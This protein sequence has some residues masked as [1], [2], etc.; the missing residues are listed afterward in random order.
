MEASPADPVALD[1][2]SLPGAGAPVSPTPATPT[3]AQVLLGVLVVWQILFL[4]AANALDV[5]RHAQRVTGGNEEV[6][7]IVDHV[8][9][10]LGHRKGHWYEVSY[11]LSRW[12]LIFNQN[13]GWGLFSPGVGDWYS[14]PQ[15][16]MRWDDRAP[17]KPALPGG[18]EPVMLRG[19]QEP[20]DLKSFTRWGPWRFQ[21]YEDYF[22]ALDLR[23]YEGESDE[24][25]AN[26][27]K[28][29]I[30][31]AME[32]EW[33]TATAYLNWRWRRYEQQHPDCPQP[34][35]L[36]L[37]VT[38]YVIARPEPEPGKVGE[39]YAVPVARLR[40]GHFRGGIWA[41]LE[42]FDPQIHQFVK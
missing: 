19:L 5:L 25:T 36:I 22:V 18:R 33:T 23:A 14:F 34:E 1:R 38:S 17:G 15:V 42:T 31:E 29:K 27:R 40:P 7:A 35:Q 11:I 13:Q 12:E 2:P 26:R 8:S 3:T 16:E 41:V 24:D 28:R 37:W 6:G 20:K 10:G 9:G 39:P 32:R 21:R 30:A 4:L